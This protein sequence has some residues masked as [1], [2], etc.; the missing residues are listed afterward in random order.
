MYPVKLNWS[1]SV[2]NHHFPLLLFAINTA[3]IKSKPFKWGHRWHA[4]MMLASILEYTLSAY[5]LNS[6]ILLTHLCTIIC[7]V[8]AYLGLYTSALTIRNNGTNE[9][10][11]ALHFH[12]ICSSYCAP[13]R[14]VCAEFRIFCLVFSKGHFSA[15]LNTKWNRIFKIRFR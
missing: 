6:F 7:M 2:K 14:S 15:E 4:G 3:K 11:T 12:F 10:E 5:D 8:Y 1:C 13:F 9:I